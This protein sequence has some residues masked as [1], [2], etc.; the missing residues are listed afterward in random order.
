MIGCLIKQEAFEYFVDFFFLNHFTVSA[1]FGGMKLAMTELFLTHPCPSLVEKS[2]TSKSDF[3]AHL[4]SLSIDEL[5]SIF[6][7]MEIKK[8]RLKSKKP[9]SLHKKRLKKSQRKELKKKN[10]KRQ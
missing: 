10:S 2:F 5:K 7:S 1:M 4:E 6:D 9:N 8:K 3:K